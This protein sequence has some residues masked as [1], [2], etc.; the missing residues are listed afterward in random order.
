MKKE[1]WKIIIQTLIT[2]LTAI[3]TT[4]GISSCI[5]A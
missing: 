1:T 4:L 3:G 2:I 5:G